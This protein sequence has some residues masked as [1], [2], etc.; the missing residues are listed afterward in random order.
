VCS[1]ELSRERH[2]P[3]KADQEVIDGAVVRSALATRRIS[4]FGGVGG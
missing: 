1:G 4:L 2:D 3:A